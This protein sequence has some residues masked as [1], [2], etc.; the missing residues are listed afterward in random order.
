MALTT[1]SLVIPVYRNEDSLHDLLGELTSL[2]AQTL[3]QH[4]TKL[5][6]VF[7]VDGSPDRSLQVL[8]Q[9]LPSASFSSKVLLHSRNFGSFAAIRTGLAASN[10][11]YIA[12]MAADLQEPPEL[13]LDF[14]ST[15]RSGQVDVV[16]GRREERGDANLGSS[17]FWTVY[18]KL[19]IKDIPPGGVDVF[20]CTRRFCTEL[21]RL[22]EANSSLVGLIYWLGF[23]RAEVGYA[24]RVRR[25]GKTA[26][27]MK[28]KITYLLDS[29]FS[30][31]DLPVR[32]LAI[33]GL[34]GLTLSILGGVIVLAS[35]LIGG[36]PVPGYAATMLA[37]LF[38]GGLNALGLGIVGSY[39]WRGFENTKGRPLSIVLTS[40]SFDGQHESLSS[41]T[42][43]SAD[44]D[45][46]QSDL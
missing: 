32:L 44:D 2:G 31:T 22:D 10:G 13:I 40:L 24:R 5:E 4:E 28:R 41:P 43:V 11:E 12:V 23:R 39:V 6:V 25:H 34:A 3:I 7:V 1:C 18:R 26:W 21:L 33:I 17:M 14:L 37:L 46:R 8:S 45:S 15:L 42:K 35:R 27:T 29:V 16:V 30:F 20:G 36:I 9:R 19:V 38:F